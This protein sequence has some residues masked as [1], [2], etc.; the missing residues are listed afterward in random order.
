M[1]IRAQ[2]K[3]ATTGKQGMTDEEGTALSN[4][5]PE[6]QVSV[7]GEIWKAVSSDKIKKGD[8]VKVIKVEGL[9]VH[10]RKVNGAE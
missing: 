7:H 3:K 8:K 4:V 9:T 2:L 5:A 10:V 1:G 6:G